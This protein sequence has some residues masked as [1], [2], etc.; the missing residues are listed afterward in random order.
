MAAEARSPRLDFGIVECCVKMGATAMSL[1]D[2]PRG[3]GGSF[4]DGRA[5]VRVFD[6]VKVDWEWRGHRL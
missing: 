3:I 2:F 6:R 5:V 4:V 1:V